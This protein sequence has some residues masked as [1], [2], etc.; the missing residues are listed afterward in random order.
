MYFVAVV[1][2]EGELCGCRNVH[3]TGHEVI[4][5]SFFLKLLAFIILLLLNFTNQL[6]V[7]SEQI[8]TVPVANLLT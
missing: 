7:C 4:V 5:D 6:S 2:S 1:Q 3:P 8:V